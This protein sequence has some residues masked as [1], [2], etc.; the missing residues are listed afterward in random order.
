MENTPTGQPFNTPKPESTTESTPASASQ[1]RLLFW[2]NN[3]WVPGGAFYAPNIPPPPTASGGNS[4]TNGSNSAGNFPPISINIPPPITSSSYTAN[5]SFNPA[6]DFVCP[7][8][9]MTRPIEDYREYVNSGGTTTKGVC[10]SC[11]EGTTPSKG[12]LALQHANMDVLLAQAA[13][14]V[15]ICHEGGDWS[16]VDKTA[17]QSLELFLLIRQALRKKE[18]WDP[19]QLRREGKL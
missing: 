5:W 10:I 13:A 9:G 8:C 14:Y 18:T 1:P 6:N 3:K 16:L 7:R 17:E 12:T 15:Q 4:T 2:R 19:S 11:I